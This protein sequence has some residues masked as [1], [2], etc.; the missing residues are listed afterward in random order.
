MLKYNKR[1][2]FFMKKIRKLLALGAVLAMLTSCASVAEGESVTVQSSHPFGISNEMYNSMMAKSLISKGNT[3]RLKNV[4][5]KLRSGEEVYI[6]TLGGSVTEGAGPANFRDGYAYQFNKL[7]RE[8]Y[9]PNEGKN[10][11]FND[12]GLSGTP[13]LLGVTRYQSDV[14]DVLDS[15]DSLLLLDGPVEV[16]LVVAAALCKVSDR[17]VLAEVLVDVFRCCN[18]D[19]RGGGIL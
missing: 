1:G 16:V 15:R 12:A 19:L 2:Y 6:A 14:V 18:Q 10:V 17:Y 9:T 13:S 11:Y 7:I 3:Y 8:K 5:E 4:I